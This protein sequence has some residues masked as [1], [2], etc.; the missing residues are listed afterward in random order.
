MTG[1]A[2]FDEAFERPGTPR[3]HYEDVLKA[4]RAKDLVAFGEDL[5]AE[6]ERRG[7]D[8]GGAPFVFDPVPRIVTA[9]EWRALEGGL[10]QR[11][12]ALNAFVTDVYGERRIVAGGI[13]PGRVIEEAVYHEPD[14]RGALPAGTPPIAVTG[15]DVVRDEAGEFRVLE[16]NV[17]TPSGLAYALAAREVMAPH[18]PARARDLRPALGHL[19]EALTASAPVADPLVVVLTDGE[20]NTAYFEHRAIAEALGIPLV[21]PE[22]CD[23]SS[24]ALV[25][26]IDGA[27]RRVDVVYRRTNCD[28]LRD[29]EGRPTGVGS[30]ML[31]PCRHGELVCLN[32]FGA[33]VADDKLAH[34]YV[35]EMVRFY[36]GEE[37]RIRSVPTYAMDD[38]AQRGKLL[39]RADEL[40]F[41][42]RAESGGEGVVIGPHADAETVRRT[43]AAVDD[44]PDRFIAQETIG[45]S[46]HPTVVDGRLEPRH[47]DLRAF[48]FA[49]PSGVRVMPGGLTRV[50]LEAGALVVNSSQDGGAKDTW[51]LDDAR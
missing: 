41:K 50:A 4:L 49:A 47:V 23:A 38:D 51:V 27:A 44:R 37:P 46:V 43:A 22:D 14:M 19:A 34:A 3:P 31:E 11:A 32:A 40:V 20:R 5:R 42:P 36:L 7:V 26:R 1:A 18:L 30:L 13:V 12:R 24:G 17:R 9:A 28:R 21:R 15:F 39:E 2:P 45:L 48:A 8:F 35:E 16:D 29:D 6:F 25:A 10:A 33:G